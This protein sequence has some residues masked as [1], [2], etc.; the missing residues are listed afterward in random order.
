MK[1]LEAGLLKQD[2][3]EQ[4]N[5]TKQQDHFRNRNLIY[6]V[7]ATRMP[8]KNKPVLHKILNAFNI[9][10][11]QSADSINT[12]NYE[13][14]RQLRSEQNTTISPRPFNQLQN[15][16]SEDRYFI[17]IRRFIYYTYRVQEAKK[18]FRVKN[19][20]RDQSSQDNEGLVDSLNSPTTIAFNPMF[21]N[22]R[23]NILATNPKYTINKNN[24]DNN[25]SNNSDDS[26]NSN[27]SNNNDNR[28]KYISGSYI[29][30]I[31]RSNNGNKIEDIIKDTYKLFLQIAT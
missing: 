15:A 20:Q 21:N 16:E 2:R 9:L 7:Q 17:Y 4:Y 29:L 10:T 23:I 26:N 11:I 13:L 8:E 28:G 25:N 30:V 12:L 14:R 1:R 24:N 6:L 5:R 19:A 31:E 27:N 3:I 22:I 18:D